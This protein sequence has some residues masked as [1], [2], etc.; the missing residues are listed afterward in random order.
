[1]RRAKPTAGWKASCRRIRSHFGSRAISVQV[2]IVAVSAH[3]FHRLFVGFLFLVSTHF[4]FGPMSLS[5]VVDASG[6][7]VPN[8]PMHLTSSNFGSFNGS[9]SDL[10][11]MGTRSGSTTD[12]KLDALLSKLVHFE[13]QIAQIPALTNWRSRM[14]SH[15]TKTLGDFATRLTEM[16]QSFST[17]TA[18]LC[19]VETY[20]A[21]AS[22]VSGS[23]GSWPSL[24][25]V[26]GST[27]AGSHGPGSSNENRSTRRRLDISSSP[28]DEHAR[29]SVLLRFSCEQHH[30]GITKWINTL[31]ERSNI[32]ADNKPVT[33]HCQA[34][35]MSVR[36]V[37]GIR[38][39]CQDFVARYKDDGIPYEIDSPFCSVI[40]TIAVRQS[41][42]IE[43]REIG[44][45]FAPLWRVLADQLKILFPDGDDEG[46]FIV[47]SLLTSPQH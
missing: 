20:A 9:G 11:G 12:D 31:W 27:A 4:C 38:G 14:D 44:K 5:R 19:K 37:F 39:K 18:R 13:T 33:I 34:G 35:S 16:E 26:D 1:M 22:N 28:A 7:Q 23:A 21:A 46:A 29:S 25:Q 41:R 8:S 6:T 45:Q 2:N 24:E 30:A 10:D 40:T 17:L 32:P 3:V 43:D 15:I 47:P 36:L 42:S